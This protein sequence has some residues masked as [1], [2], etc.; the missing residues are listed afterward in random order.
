MSR[1]AAQRL[2]SNG[3]QGRRWGRRMIRSA[4]QVFS[5]LRGEG[6]APT[7]PPRSSSGPG[8]AVA[9]LGSRGPMAQQT[10]FIETAANTAMASP[11]E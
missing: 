2:G 8:L 4:H 7:Y 11:A 9:D 1:G 5:N 10:S 6:M 3:E